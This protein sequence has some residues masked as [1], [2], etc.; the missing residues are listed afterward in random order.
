MNDYEKAFEKALYKIAT[1]YTYWE[2]KEVI[3][4]AGRK[5][6]T[7]TS[8][9]VPAD[10]KACIYLLHKNNPSEWKYG[11]TEEDSKVL[12]AKVREVLSGIPSVIE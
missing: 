7:R 5:T 3:D 1:G 9:H 2:V 6:I 10:P 12:F 11:I 8:H 4:K